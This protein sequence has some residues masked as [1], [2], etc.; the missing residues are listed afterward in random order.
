MSSLSPHRILRQRWL[1][2]AS[3]QEQA[4]AIRKELRSGLDTGLLPVFER[5]FDA[6]AAG[7]ELVRIPRLSLEL[8]LRPG[9]DFIAALTDALHHELSEVL[10][11]AVVAH[12]GQSGALRLSLRTSRRQTLLRYLASG[13]I[14]RHVDTGD[15]DQLLPLLRTEAVAFANEELV[16]AGIIGGSLSQRIAAGFRLL[17]LLPAEPRHSVLAKAPLYTVAGLPPELPVGGE[18]TVALLP[19]VLQRLLASDISGSYLR[20]RVQA[21]LLALQTEDLRFPLDAHIV[22]LLQE[23]LKQLAAQASTAPLCTILRVLIDPAVKTESRRTRQMRSG[24]HGNAARDPSDPETGRQ[25]AW[26]AS[27][28]RSDLAE[29]GAAIPGLQPAGDAP[30]T[31]TGYPASDAGLVLLHP[32]LS[33]L[34]IAVGI[35]P[36]GTAELPEAVLPR[37]AALLHW[38]MSGRE[39]VYEFELTTVKVLLGLAPDRMLLVGNGLLSDTDK[40]E[41]HALLAAAIAHWGALGKTGVAAL[42]TSFLQRRGLLRDIGSGWQLQVEPESFDMLLGKLPWGISIVRLPWMTR[43]IF[44]EWPTP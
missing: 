22:S 43:P 41:A 24:A 2:K 19:I 10:H 26:R 29:A 28:R 21:L 35:T 18:A 14:E 32:F 44:I 30:D 9:E 25:A 37:A 7:D 8:K 40:E 36:A 13:H 1:V 38:L 33:R 23:C 6:F 15:A 12:P 20:L 16:L 34:F 17:Q 3:S 4:F 31:G 5:A 39:E 11:E 42:R 27:E